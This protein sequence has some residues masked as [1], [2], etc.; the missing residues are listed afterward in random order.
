MDQKRRS[1]LNWFRLPSLRSSLLLA[2][3]T[4]LNQRS[5]LSLGKRPLRNLLPGWPS[6]TR[7]LPSK[8]NP[9]QPL[10]AFGDVRIK[11]MLLLR[12]TN[13]ACHPRALQRPPNVRR[14]TRAS[15][16]SALLQLTKLA[17]RRLNSTRGRLLHHHVLAS[18]YRDSVPH[19]CRAVDRLL[20][21]KFGAVSSRSS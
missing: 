13:N 17:V 4:S 16:P 3:S 1:S 10:I 20:G 11:A 21:R 15:P 2:S 9:V 5:S 7:A 14:L 8:T 19:R 6:K 18:V 12:R